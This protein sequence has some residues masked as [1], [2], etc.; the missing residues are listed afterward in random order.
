MSKD[1]SINHASVELSGLP[2]RLNKKANEDGMEL[3]DSKGTPQGSSQ[4]GGS[5]SLPPLTFS[6]AAKEARLFEPT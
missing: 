5:C 2:L 1:P 6:L 3:L 4:S